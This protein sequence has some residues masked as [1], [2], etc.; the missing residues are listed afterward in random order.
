MVELAN[1]LPNSGGI[2]SWFTGD[3]DIGSFGKQLVTFGKSFAEYYESI[4]DV[5][6]SKLN[7]VVDEFSKLVDLA[8]G[9]KNV[10]TSG[11]S[12]FAKNLKDLAKSGIDEFIKAFEESEKRV[13]AAVDT[14]LI[15]FINTADSYEGELTGTFVSLVDG[16]ISSISS[17]YTKFT[18]AGNGVMSNFMSGVKSNDSSSRSVFASIMSGCLSSITNRYQ[19]FKNAGITIINNV[20]NGIKTKRQSAK[21]EFTSIVNSCLSLVQG[22]YTE[23]YNAGKNLVQG[24]ANGINEYTWYAEA[25]ARAMAN[26]AAAAAEDE[27]DINSPSKVGYGIGRFFGKG[28]VNSIIDYSDKAYKAGSEMATSAKDGLRNT[29]SKISDCIDSSIDSQPTIRPVLDLSQVKEG[30]GQL[31]AMLSKN[32]AMAISSGIERETTSKV[33]NDNKTPAVGNSYNFVQN[34]Y[35]PKALSRIDIY[36]QTKNQFSAMKGLVET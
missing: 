31:S 1:N 14:M 6:V 35:S 33:Q 28:F 18:N 5:N 4:R 10:D 17:Q 2:V 25:K 16:I 9:I 12:K 15:S 11:M 32:Q 3:N 29:I 21:T 19:E 34:N 13:D 27:L 26:A 22:K 23:F 30:A 24:F 7:G 36:R 8:K 20:V